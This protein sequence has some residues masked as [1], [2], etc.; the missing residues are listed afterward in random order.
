[1]ATDALREIAAVFGINFDPEGNLKRGDKETNSLVETLK[2]ATRVAAEAFAFDKL[3]EFVAGTI[4]A[5][6]R[7]QDLSS[8][9]G[10]GTK[11]LQ[12]FQ[13]AAGQAG[14]D[15]DSAS[16]SI[17]L[18]NRTIGNTV[19]GQGGKEAAE[20]FGK[21]G[22]KIKG[23][24]GQVRPL[25]D[26]LGDVADGIAALPNQQERA[27]AAM[28]LFGRQGQ[29]LLPMLQEGREGL[30]G[31]RKEFDELG[32][33]M[34]T[35]FIE[36]S[37]KIADES[38]KLS[39]WWTRLKSDIVSQ[40]LPGLTWTVKE[41][42]LGAKAVQDLS[43]HTNFLHTAFLFFS[44]A[45]L[46]K[47][48]TQLV[49]LLKTLGILKPTI[50]GTVAALYEFALPIATVAALY[51]IFD[52]F[53]TMLKGGRSVIGQTLIQLLG[54]KKGTEA[55]KDLNEAVKAT[56]DL[57]QN[58]GTLIINAL[59]IPLDAAIDT[60][61]GLL[62]VLGAIGDIDITNPASFKKAWENIK[63]ISNKAGQDI[64]DD[65]TRDAA[66]IG[67]AWK[68]MGDD[69]TLSAR[70]RQ[71]K[72]ARERFAQGNFADYAPGGS[73]FAGP[74]PSKKQ[75]ARAASVQRRAA[76]LEAQGKTGFVPRHGAVVVTH[77]GGATVNQTNN[78]HT[79][80]TTTG[81]PTKVA[82]GTAKGQGAATESQL[83]HAAALAAT[84]R[85]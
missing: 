50:Q 19:T 72:A 68:G 1:M 80:I 39:F 66:A 5:G 25:I 53:Y 12:F 30:D 46:P 77:P 51:L 23:T 67:K 41:L 26:I 31:L 2:K 9:L 24:A 35:E 11:D 36:Q 81:D 63:N 21:L 57:L 42:V 49:G 74:M 85:S 10:L 54:I 73:E 20:T 22:V 40:L 45:A 47:V 43:K 27:A 29:Q 4:E 79:K 83:K 69:F 48:G 62:K 37:K 28:Q 75:A 44:A 70:G 17:G 82:A 84:D 14:V 13:F 8:R 3:K 52:D 33:G 58:L 7:M 60:A 6:A 61:E 65:A 34:S 38:R 59:F 71:Q 64:V 76:K 16:R 18:L 55:Q 15:A 32:G 78:F 56:I